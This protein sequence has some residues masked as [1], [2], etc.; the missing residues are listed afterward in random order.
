MTGHRKKI[1][2]RTGDRQAFLL[3]ETK[4]LDD[5]PR[6]AGRG[7]IPI[8]IKELS[9]RFPKMPIGKALVEETLRRLEPV[10]AFAVM[11]LRLD[12]FFSLRQAAGDEAAISLLLDAAVVVD[13]GC[14]AGGGFWGVIEQDLI[15]VFL[16]EQTESDARDLAEEI[17]QV[18]S[19]VRGETL[20]AGITEYPLADYGRLD[21]LK[22][23][24]KALLHARFLG[25]GGI[26]AFDAV[27]L[28]ISADRLFQEGNIHGAAEELKAALKM[29]PA[30]ADIRNS[31]GVCYASLGALH[32]ALR[33]F[34]TAAGLRREGIM[35]VHNIGLVHEMMGDPEKALMHL[36]EADRLLEAGR[37]AE[38]VFELPYQIGRIYLQEGLPEKAEP[39]LVR[40]AALNPASGAAWRKL[41]ECLL[42]RGDIHGAAAAFGS[43]VKSNPSDAASLSELGILFHRKGENPEIALLFC[44]HSI[45][46]SPRNG[47]YRQN[48]G[49]L[50]LAMNRLDE[51]LAAFQRAH[52]LGC[53]S[54]AYIDRIRGSL[55]PS[56]EISQKKETA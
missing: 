37:D 5:A 48:L 39:Y 23:A 13:E 16:P 35:P 25:P 54:R 4:E 31:L 53:D 41:G 29:N 21:T 50:C 20:T 49:K 9:A 34:K 26:A 14:R 30:D 1:Y 45:E 51:A 27:S 52:D 2:A 36:I 24:R 17:R 15:G 12:D 32:A 22:N 7:R 56:E 19:Q 33:E 43:A 10:P 44:R 18:F 40:A 46:I 55:S 38:D 3:Y 6:P 42:A 8:G 47:T 28:N 11:L